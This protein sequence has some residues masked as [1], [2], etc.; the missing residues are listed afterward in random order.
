MTAF[1]LLLSTGLAI[2]VIQNLSFIDFRAYKVGV[3][4]NTAMQPS[5]A[6]EYSYVMSRG[7][8]QVIFD[9]YPT[10]DEYEFVEMTLRNPEALPT[11]SD[12]SVW[13]EQ[14]DFTEEILTKKRILILISNIT[15]VNERNFDD[16]AALIQDL[17]GTDVRI[18]VV[19]SSSEEEIQA[20]VKRLEWDVDY[21]MAD[22]TVLK[23]IIR[24]NP[25]LMVMQEGVILGKYHHNNTPEA[26]QVLELFIPD[27]GLNALKSFSKD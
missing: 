15:K 18:S 16:I 27:A 17:R 26:S 25:G 4:I 12:F 6:L 19:S 20:M 2:Y 3:D 13:N 23:T 11:I 10:D 8:E 14:G 5:A 7:G 21:Y 22:A 1:S 24:S 9:Q